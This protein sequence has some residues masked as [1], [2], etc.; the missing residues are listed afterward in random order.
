MYNPCAG[1]GEDGEDEY[2]CPGGTEAE[3]ACTTGGL[4]ATFKVQPATPANPNNCHP[5]REIAV[6]IDVPVCVARATVR[7]RRQAPDANLVAIVIGVVG[8]VG[9]VVVSVDSALVDA[10]LC[11]VTLHDEFCLSRRESV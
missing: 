8:V 2:P 1:K 10:L 6:V 9:V 11:G 3:P 4:C 7:V 5:H